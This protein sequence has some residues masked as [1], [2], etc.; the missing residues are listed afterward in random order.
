MINCRNCLK[1]LQRERSRTKSSN[2]TKTMTMRLA[3]EACYFQ[4]L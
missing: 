2:K 4:Y 1:R 3:N